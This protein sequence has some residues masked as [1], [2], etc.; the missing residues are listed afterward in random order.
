MQCSCPMEQNMGRVKKGL[1]GINNEMRDYVCPTTHAEIDAFNKIRNWKNVPKKLDLYVIRI[2]KTGIIG[3][4]RPCEHCLRRLMASRINII[5]CYYSTKDKAIVKEKFKNMLGSDLT[6]VSS[7]F[8]S[9][10]LKKK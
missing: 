8:M 1:F 4:S 3:D 10:R 6:Y 7:G 5:D 2:S 9:T